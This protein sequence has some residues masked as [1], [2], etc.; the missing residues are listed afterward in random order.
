MST[1]TTPININDTFPGEGISLGTFDEHAADRMF[2]A[3][4]RP[5]THEVT[6]ALQTGE[7]YERPPFETAEKGP[8]DA[9]VNTLS[10]NWKATYTFTRADG[11]TGERTLNFL[12]AN[13]YQSANMRA[14]NIVSEGARLLAALGY[15]VA[16][17]GQFT[18]E[19]IEAFLNGASNRGAKLKIKTGLRYFDKAADVEFTTNP[20]KN[21][22]KQRQWPKA[23]NGQPA[24]FLTPENTGGVITTKTPG[25]VS[26]LD[27]YKTKN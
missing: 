25:R 22:E 24:F 15:T 23:D 10:V 7:G 6:F 19:N 13:F 11:T 3:D 2:P 18:R 17:D 20:R 5:G 4:P 27:Y 9:K 8:A 16:N 26:V 21:Q 12:N 14:K 1:T